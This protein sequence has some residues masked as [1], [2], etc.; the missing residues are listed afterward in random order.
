MG[1]RTASKCPP[2]SNPKYSQLRIYRDTDM[3]S[4]YRGRPN[5]KYSPLANSRIQLRDLSECILTALD[6]KQ[7]P[8]QEAPIYYSKMMALLQLVTDP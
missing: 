4:K 3:P 7:N 1:Y 8:S 5:P 6:W 2:R